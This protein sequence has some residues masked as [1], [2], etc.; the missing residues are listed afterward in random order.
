M[1]QGTLQAPGFKS[2]LTKLPCANWQRST[3]LHENS[4]HPSKL[5]QTVQVMTPALVKQGH[6]VFA[7]T[8]KRPRP[9]V[10]KRASKERIN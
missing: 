7:T 3:S 9:S 4:S 5:S 6:T 10:A 2:V 8:L 1:Q